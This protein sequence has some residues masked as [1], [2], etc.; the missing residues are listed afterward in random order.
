MSG[1]REREEELR[2]LEAENPSS[3]R[4]QGA[5]EDN[6]LEGRDIGERYA[7]IN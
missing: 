4:Q 3:H 1:Q 5:A 2:P 6:F 7:K